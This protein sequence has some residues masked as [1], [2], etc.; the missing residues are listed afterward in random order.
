MVK[1][2]QKRKK[3]ETFASG[4][5]VVTDFKKLKKAD[6]P[7]YENGGM[8]FMHYD[9]KIYFDSEDEANEAIIMAFKLLVQ[10]P[11]SELRKFEREQKRRHPDIKTAGD[12][13][14][15]KGD[16]EAFMKALSMLLIPLEIKSR[17]TQ[18][19]YYGII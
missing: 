1:F 9:G 3:E 12:L 17:E 2:L 15:L 10:H 4:R 6:F 7:T 13:S 19:D 8:F 16:N 18:R 5:I 11:K 14:K